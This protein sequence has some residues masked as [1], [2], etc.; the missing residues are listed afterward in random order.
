MIALQH[1][2]FHHLF[3]FWTVAK[4]GH[5]TRAANQL[6]VSQ[7]ALSSQIRKLEEQ[8]GYDLFIREGKTLILTELG[9]VV[10]N[11]A[12]GIFALGNELLSTVNAGEGQAMQQ[13]RVGAVSTLSRNFQENFLR[14]VLELKN[15]QLFLESRSLETLLSHLSVHKLDL[16]LS[17]Q[18][19][20]A[21][22]NESWRCSRI[23]RQSVCLVGPPR[24]PK[25]K[26]FKFPNDL[27]SIKLLL[28]GLNSDIRNQFDLLCENLKFDI[29]VFAEVDDMAM[30]RLLTRDYGGA[31]VVP[32]VVVQDELL[33]G[34][35]EK[36]CIIPK[37][38]ENFYAITTKRYFKTTALDKLLNTKKSK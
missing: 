34:K 37:V 15:V 8:F 25:N 1:L 14:P 31:A 18:P 35:L 21:D 16:I 22:R 2:N 19:V 26:K 13:L 4:E 9:T 29:D 32:E 23:A 36:Y 17:N 38:Y 12:E 5:L 20:S 27:A 6:H 11:Y 33:S 24:K 7:S 28:P 10:L 3:Y 30:L